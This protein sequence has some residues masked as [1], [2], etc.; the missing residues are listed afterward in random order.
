V[1]AVA[2]STPLEALRTGGKRAMAMALARLEAAAGEPQTLALLDAAYAGSLAHVI[3]L[4]GPPGVGKS[5]LTSR[6]I[7]AYR[8]RGRTVGV[9]TVD[10]S[11]RKSGGA[12]LGDRAR[13]DADPGDQGV[14]VRSMAARGRLGGLAALTPAAVVLMR[15]VYDQVIV[16]TVGVGQS[17]TEVAAVADTV[18]FC[19]Q[20]AS[21][22]SLQ[23][24]KAGIAEIPDIVVVT[25]ADLGAVA[26][27]AKGD[28]E[29]ALQLN[30]AGTEGWKVPVQL[31]SG[32]EGQGIDAL[33][34]V[35]AEHATFLAVD[36]RLEQRRA[37][38]AEAWLAEA[39]REEFGRQGLERVG[40]WLEDLTTPLGQSPFRRLR[41][42]ARRL[43]TETGSRR[44][45]WEAPRN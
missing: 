6:L 32:V 44:F 5:S 33:I 36:G 25:K 11:S 28:V 8:A 21:G 37:A 31:L 39:L 26:R 1:S 13:I 27:K 15:S 20:P 30:L 3:G 45:A 23:Y 4:T 12:L 17:E 22:D 14:F 38:Q 9:I 41:E 24:M 35:L 19:V 2:G 7:R 16:E 42:L 29:A 40:G 10:P 34:D 18:V 43:R